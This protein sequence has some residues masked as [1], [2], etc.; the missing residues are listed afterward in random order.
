[1]KETLFLIL[2][3][4]L[5]CLGGVWIVRR[6]FNLRAN[7]ELIT[8]IGVGLIFENWSANLAGTNSSRNDGFLAGTG[9]CFADRIGILLDEFARRLAVFIS[10]QGSSLA[11]YA[12]ARHGVCLLYGRA[13]FG[14]IG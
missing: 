14:S 3:I 13:R 2:W 4:T 7:E 10:F 9:H 8:G 1:M 11:G 5:W 12:A 6:A